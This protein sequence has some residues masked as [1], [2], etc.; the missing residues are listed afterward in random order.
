VWESG[1]VG[2]DILD[3]I[4]IVYKDGTSASH[5]GNG[6]QGY[7]RAAADLHFSAD[8]TII[9]AYQQVLFEVII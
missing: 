3:G 9:K 5:K 2:R 8:A 1:E 6:G 4:A 7:E